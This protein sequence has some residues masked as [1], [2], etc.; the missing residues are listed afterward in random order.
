MDFIK[1][2]PK[3]YGTEVILVVVDRL[4][5][6]AHFLALSHLFT[7]ITMAQLF[8]DHVF[9]L[10]GMPNSI[11]S[12]KDKVFMSQFWQELF[13]RFDTQLKLFTAYHP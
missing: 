12:D 5:K 7:A 9:K 10:H 6:C 8:L 3:S 11:V 13:R 2:L 1:G 4:T